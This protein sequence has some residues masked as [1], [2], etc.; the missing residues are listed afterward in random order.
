MND[1]R[2]HEEWMDAALVERLLDGDD[3]ARPDD[4]VA[5]L[6]RVLTAAAEPGPGNPEHER[7]ALAAFREARDAYGGSA[8]R[9]GPWHS[10]RG[11]RAARQTRGPRPLRAA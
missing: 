4:R 6:A 1:S 9:T 5:D 7:A 3:V 11:Y 8:A 10:W 2:E